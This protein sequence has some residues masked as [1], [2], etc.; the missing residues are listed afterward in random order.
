MVT[1]SESRRTSQKQT[2]KQTQKPDLPSSHGFINLLSDARARVP[3]CPGDVFNCSCISTGRWRRW[4]SSAVL[5]SPVIS[6]VFNSC[7]IYSAAGVF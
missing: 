5:T 7:S 2:N 1:D 3:T 6:I 4:P